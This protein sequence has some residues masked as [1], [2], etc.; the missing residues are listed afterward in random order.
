M[1]STSSAAQIFPMT[2]SKTVYPKKPKVELETSESIAAQTQQFLSKGGQIDQI[3]IG[4]SGVDPTVGRK[5]ISIPKRNK[6]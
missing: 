5:H 3:N 2:K 4:V 6:G 1:D